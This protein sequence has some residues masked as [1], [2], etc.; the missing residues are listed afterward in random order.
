M[1][2]GQALGGA[3]QLGGYGESSSTCVRGMTRAVAEAAGKYTCSNPQPCS[4]RLAM[5]RACVAPDITL[6]LLALPPTRYRSPPVGHCLRLLPARCGQGGH[7]GSRQAAARARRRA[8]RQRGGAGAGDAG[9][10]PASCSTR[11]LRAVIKVC[12]AGGLGCE[13]CTACVSAQAAA[14]PNLYAQ[15]HAVSASHCYFVNI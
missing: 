13:A 6:L 15:H 10:P 2:W 3:V 9:E 11:G 1:G 7:A 5:F 8:G 4:S 14:A 12:A